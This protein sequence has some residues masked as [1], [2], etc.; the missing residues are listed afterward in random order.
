M[1]RFILKPFASTGGV[2]GQFG[3]FEANGG[4][5]GDGVLTDDN[6][7]I[8]GLP[9]WIDGWDAATNNALKLPRLEEMNGVQKV[10][11]EFAIQNFEDGITYWQSGM[12]VTAN[13][14]VVQY[15]G[16]LY[17]NI[18]GTNT[19]TAPDSD[20]TN[21]HFFLDLTKEY[22]DLTSAQ[23]ISGKKTFTSNARND[24]A[25]FI[26]KNTAFNSAST[27]YQ[28]TLFDISIL[29]KD[30]VKRS[31]ITSGVPASNMTNIAFVVRDNAGSQ[32]SYLSVNYNSATGN[33]WASCPTPA[34]TSSGDEVI[35][36]EWF[37]QKSA[38]P[39]LN[40]SAAVS[41]STTTWRVGANEYGVVTVHLIAPNAGSAIDAS[42]SSNTSR[43]AM[44]A[45]CS[46]EG[47]GAGSII[48]KPNDY[49][50]FSPTAGGYCNQCR[51]IPFL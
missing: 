39:K 49:I 36:A 50:V 11:S 28:D 3:S 51:F 6:D 42:I 31:N 8:Q 27:Q 40:L 18:T 44:F 29:D 30:G 12:S 1:T 45:A 7:T 24:G 33:G 37:N 19:A 43:G 9:A 14:T 32:K 10:F 5:V 15:N 17:L 48:V 20:T 46:Q 16:K 21:W 13:Q 41:K 47:S 26:A 22:V 23:S 35:T 38:I 34:L 4:Q 2:T 25:G